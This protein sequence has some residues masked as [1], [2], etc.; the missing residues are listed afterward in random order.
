MPVV[1]RTDALAIE[2]I[3]GAARR[4]RAYAEAG[5]DLI[6][7]DAVRTEEQVKRIVDAARVPVTINM[8][9]G[10]RSRPTTPLEVMKE[11]IATGVPVDRPDLAQHA[12]QRHPAHAQLLEPRQRNERSA[13]RT[14][15]S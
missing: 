7:P 6:F 8:R 2:G 13:S 10:I 3:D 4:A 15:C 1:A 11:V 12:R 5:A 14:S 9:F